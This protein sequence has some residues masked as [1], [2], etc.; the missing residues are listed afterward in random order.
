MFEAA[1]VELW[2]NG[3]ILIFGFVQFF[4]SI[5]ELIIVLLVL[6]RIVKVSSSTA[7][8]EADERAVVERRA[9]GDNVSFLIRLPHHGLGVFGGAFYFF[10]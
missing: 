2:W 7:A 8:A 10:V 5:E 9:E 1:L 4:S 3:F 6:I